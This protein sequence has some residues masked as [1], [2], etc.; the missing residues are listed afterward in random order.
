MIA[1]QGSAA[2]KRIS[3]V[4]D[5][6]IQ[7]FNNENVVEA[8]SVILKFGLVARKHI[9][10]QHNNVISLT[11]TDNFGLSSP[12]YSMNIDVIPLNDKPKFIPLSGLYVKP[13]LTLC[14]GIFKW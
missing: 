14:F 5:K 1:Y 8:S 13:A 4:I 7:I 2:F 10:G 3:D 9:T 12:A 11:V 6:E